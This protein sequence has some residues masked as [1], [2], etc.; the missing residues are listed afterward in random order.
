V[1]TL[2]GKLSLYL[3]AGDAGGGKGACFWHA[4]GVEIPVAPGQAAVHCLV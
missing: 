3:K 2:S 1:Q 4:F